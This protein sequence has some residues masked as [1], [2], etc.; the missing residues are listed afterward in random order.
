MKARR[1]FKSV[2]IILLLA[3][4][5]SSCFNG[6]Q[7]DVSSTESDGPSTPEESTVYDSFSLA[8]NSEKKLNPFTTDS[9]LNI[10]ISQLVTEPLVLINAD[11]DKEKVLLESITA[12]TGN[13]VYK[14]KIKENRLFSDGTE[15]TPKDVESSVKAILSNSD[16]YYYSYVKNIASVGAEEDGTLIFTL[17]LPDP[18][19]E[20]MLCFPIVKN[21]S[22]DEGYI[23]S[24]AYIFAEDEE[25]IYL[26]A[27]ETHEVK[28]ATV[29]LAPTDNALKL[30]TML[31]S[32]DIDYYFT[33]DPS[34]TS[35]SFSGAECVTDQ[36]GMMLF[37]TSTGVCADRELRYAIS[38]L[39]D[40]ERIISDSGL[41]AE[42]YGKF[43]FTEDESI[44]L[45]I[46]NY[47]TDSGYNRVDE[48]GFRY[49][50]SG[51]KNLYFEI[52]IACVETGNSN[53]VSDSI[54]AILAEQGVKTVI[55]R[56][57]SLEKLVE[58]TS[59]KNETD[60]GKAFDIA[61]TEINITPNGDISALLDNVNGY[62]CALSKN[63][64]QMQIYMQ[65]LQGSIN[66]EEFENGLNTD[67][68]VMSLYRCKG[69][70]LY[71]RLF[72]EGI[73]ISPYTPYYKAENWYI[74]E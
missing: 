14:A 1:I 57:S 61:L 37:N 10:A 35:G 24:G 12:E 62:A 33:T 16:G 20:R 55:T 39:I 40:R 52:S 74:Y 66:L 68:S 73:E 48:E 28:T 58:F 5:L 50:K 29:R 65:Y 63:D 43:T 2:F 26:K 30:H 46:D 45:E 34:V 38:R 19:F 49:K 22:K 18:E 51:G 31:Q 67:F 13:L 11:G 25:G 32:G 3:L 4:F 9:F 59:P 47:L 60:L 54:S 36:T 8:Y 15:I 17:K 42:A 7:T 6:T 27:A 56:F 53:K 70:I 69:K 72:A 21:G 23:G 64:L 41:F 44:I 71:N